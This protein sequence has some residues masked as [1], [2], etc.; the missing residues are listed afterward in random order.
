MVQ[1]QFLLNQAQVVISPSLKETTLAAAVVVAVTLEAVA[2]DEAAM[3]LIVEA[4]EAEV[5][6][7]T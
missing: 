2:A 1:A 5:D 6:Q 7:V 3:A 4:A